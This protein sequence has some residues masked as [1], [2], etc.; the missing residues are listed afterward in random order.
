MRQSSFPQM[1]IEKRGSGGS[2]CLKAYCVCEIS[3]KYQ[4]EPSV[5][6]YI[7]NMENVIH[8]NVNDEGDRSRSSSLRFPLIGCC[9]S[10]K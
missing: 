8:G 4:R 6:G 9:N 10:G 5:K 3:P 1:S 2:G 7:R